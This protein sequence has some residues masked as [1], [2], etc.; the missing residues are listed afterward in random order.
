LNGVL[1]EILFEV[2]QKF[3]RTKPPPQSAGTVVVPFA[4]ESLIGV[5]IGVR[6]R[7]A[8]I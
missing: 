3:S 2:T 8:L 1:S 7:V 6:S 5:M 4:S